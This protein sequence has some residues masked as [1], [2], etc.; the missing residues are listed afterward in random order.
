MTMQTEQLI[1]YVRIQGA[2]PWSGVA[3]LVEE[4]KRHE[5]A[6]HD[7]KRDTN[8]L[9]GLSKPEQEALVGDRKFYK[10]AV[11]FNSYNTDWILTHA[12][13]KAVLDYACGNGAL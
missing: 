3:D 10:A 8:Y 12:P 6:L 7:Q 11:D 1:D 2:P 4:R 13:G 5:I 9:T